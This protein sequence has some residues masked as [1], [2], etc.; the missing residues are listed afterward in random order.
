MDSEDFL[1]SNLLLPLGSLIFVLFCTTKFGW[2]ADN[3]LKETN[4]GTG[5]KM[6][7]KLIIYFKYILPV[8]IIVILISG[9]L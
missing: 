1:V 5:I 4:T 7:R 6:S 3:Y 8:L 2:G 9:L